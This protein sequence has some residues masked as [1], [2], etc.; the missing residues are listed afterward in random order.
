MGEYETNDTSKGASPIDIK[1]IAFAIINNYPIVTYESPQINIPGKKCNYKI[2]LIC[3][4]QS[5]E[6]LSMVE[7][8]HCIAIKI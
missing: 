3:K 1:L 4:E 5:V 7:F 8:L 2:P 6:C